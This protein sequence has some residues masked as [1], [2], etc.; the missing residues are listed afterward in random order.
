[1]EQKYIEQS[2]KLQIHWKLGVNNPA[3]DLMVCSPGVWSPLTPLDDRE[4]GSF[5]PHAHRL[6][7]ECACLPYT[8]PSPALDPNS[9][10]K[11]DFSE[12]VDIELSAKE[13]SA[14][15]KGNACV[16][17][18][19]GPETHCLLIVRLKYSND[20]AVTWSEYSV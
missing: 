8:A 12:I 16:S 6:C 18:L 19:D 14:L 2:N 9:T 7:V 13:V 10:A 1:M 4:A 15:Y 20:G 17:V 3:A 11:F 5:Q